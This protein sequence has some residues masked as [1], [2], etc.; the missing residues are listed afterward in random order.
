MN[1][2]RRSDLTPAAHAML[3]QYDEAVRRICRTGV[4]VS[5]SYAGVG[6]VADSDAM[7]N[8]QP[9]DRILDVGAFNTY[10]GA[11]SRPAFSA[12]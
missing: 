3:A 2:Y 9:E 8:A 10:L 12:W 1:F 11:L 7:E 6:I 5:H 4:P